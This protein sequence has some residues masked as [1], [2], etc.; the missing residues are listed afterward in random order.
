MLI[1]NCIQCI[2]FSQSRT[3]KEVFTHKTYLW[4]LVSVTSYK[5]TYLF[6]HKREFATL[7]IWILTIYW[8]CKWKEGYNYV[9]TFYCIHWM[10]QPQ[11][12]YLIWDLCHK[13]VLWVKTSF[14]VRLCEKCKPISCA[15]ESNK[16]LQVENA[17][18]FKLINTN[19]R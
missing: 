15:F 17:M 10:S 8:I 2:H 3:L 7:T 5:T 14:S 16:W 6:W 11:S 19:I 4:H 9:R 18:L 13:Y 12:A 1:I